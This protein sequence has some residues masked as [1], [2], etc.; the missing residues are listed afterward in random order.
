MTTPRIDRRS[1]SAATTLDNIPEHVK[2][3]IDWLSFGTVVAAVWG[4]IP[5][6]ALILTAVWTAIRIYESETV[7]NII[8]WL[9]HR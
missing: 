6:L 2:A 8:A 3:A 7:Q 5:T 4:A 1:R 9:R